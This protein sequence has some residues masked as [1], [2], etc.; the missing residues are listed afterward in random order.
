MSKKLY[1]T[2]S[3]FGLLTMVLGQFMAKPQ[4][5]GTMVGR[6]WAHVFWLGLV[7][8]TVPLVK[9]FIGYVVH[10]NDS[11]VAKAGKYELIGLVSVTCIA[12]LV[13]VVAMIMGDDALT[14]YD[15]DGRK[16]VFVIWL[17]M[18]TAFTVVNLFTLLI[19]RLRQAKQP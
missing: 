12:G 14:G 16:G 6:A 8:F 13:T 9:L 19:K 4:F 1:L 11:L 17:L 18:I 7:L 5:Y 2:A 15:G 10:H 3:A